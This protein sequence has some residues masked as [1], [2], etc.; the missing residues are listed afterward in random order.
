[1]AV[2]RAV[3]HPPGWMS[4]DS[5]AKTTAWIRSRGPSL[6]SARVTWVLTVGS[7]RN[8]LAFAAL[9]A[10][11]VHVPRGTAGARDHVTPS[12]AMSALPPPG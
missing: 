5:E 4:P 8:Y 9:A 6:L 7:L 12:D 2:A 1:M 3:V 11:G 10:I